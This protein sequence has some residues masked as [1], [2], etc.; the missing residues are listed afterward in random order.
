VFPHFKLPLGCPL[1]PPPPALNFSISCP[2]AR[3]VFVCDRASPFNPLT[4]PGHTSS[5]VFFPPT[6]PGALFGFYDLVPCPLRF[7]PLLLPFSLFSRTHFDLLFWMVVFF[8]SPWSSAGLRSWCDSP[9]FPFFLMSPFLFVYCS[10]DDSPAGQASRILGYYESDCLVL[11]LPVFRSS[12]P[13]TLSIV[14]QCQG[15][16]PG[17]LQDLVFLS[18][19]TPFWEK[20]VEIKERF[21]FFSFSLVF[22][23]GV[24]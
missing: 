14:P 23:D 19:S 21:C 24:T 16:I 22:R 2:G 17:L 6:N 15:A 11:F 9:F 8:S 20:I 13:L 18:F 10:V 4:L 12:L 3:M 1:A 5:L 7:P